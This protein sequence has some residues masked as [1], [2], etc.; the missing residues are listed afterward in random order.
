MLNGHYDYNDL[1]EDYPR[2]ILK[3][4]SGK[5]ILNGKETLAYRL[6]YDTEK[7]TWSIVR[8]SKGLEPK[9]SRGRMV[10]FCNTITKSLWPKETETDI[11]KGKNEGRWV[12]PN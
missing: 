4:P 1:Y 7:T 8:Y 6:M 10:S 9:T 3:I 12:W 2:W 5:E 11:G